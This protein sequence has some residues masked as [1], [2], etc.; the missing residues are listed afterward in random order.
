MVNLP[1]PSTLQLNRFYTAEFF[2]NI[3]NRLTED[4]VFSFSLPGSLSYISREQA[5]LNGSILATL[6]GSLRPN[7]IPGDNNLYLASKKALEISPELYISRLEGYGIKT[8][9]MNRQYFDHRLDVKVR[10]W[11]FKE[12][13]RQPQVRKNTDLLPS[14][15]F[16]SIWYWSTLFSKNFGQF[17]GVID[18]LNMFILLIALGIVGAVLMAARSALP[19]PE[20]VCACFVL[21]STGFVGMSLNLIIIYAYQSFYGFI[22]Q[23]IAMLV[24]AFMAGLALGSYVMNMKLSSTKEGCGSFFMI[25]LACFGYC[26]T[27]IPAILF[28]NADPKPAMAW[29]LFASSALAGSFV[30]LE[31]PL[32]NKVYAG[33][34]DNAARASGIVYAVDLI[35]SWLA[36]L[37]VSVA[38]VPVIGI[39][40]TCLFLAALK[41]LSLMLVLMNSKN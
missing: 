39:T 24:T 38:L 37:V 9:L 41:G 3:R 34:A 31:F 6:E 18:R 36:A 5:R 16:Y 32:A 27:M 4:G 11:F 17:F 29:I 23:Q 12:I 21:G 15:T 2:R 14:G 28:L 19:R 33:P 8:A 7:V 22:F 13:S 1:M 10:E 25:E 26:L 20:K 40:W 35:G 30:G